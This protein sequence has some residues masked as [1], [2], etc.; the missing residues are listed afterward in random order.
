MCEGLEV[1]CRNVP[2]LDELPRLGEDCARIGHVP[3]SQVRREHGTQPRTGVV[4][5]AVR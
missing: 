2:A 5:H 4:G 3:V 1:V